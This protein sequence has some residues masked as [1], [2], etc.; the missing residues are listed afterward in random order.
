VHPAEEARAAG[1]ELNWS[2]RIPYS[3]FALAAAETVRINQPDYHE[4]FNAAIF[5][6]YFALGKDI[7]EWAVI[8][9]CADDV[10]VDPFAFDYEM[11]CG[12]ADN[13]LRY[14]EAQDQEH[15][16]NATASWLAGDQVA[17]GPR[18][19]PCSP[20]SAAPWVEK[21]SAPPVTRP[22]PRKPQCT[23]STRRR[24][25]LNTTSHTEEPPWEP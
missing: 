13:E 1:M 5:R 21:T 7:G 9:D 15:D 8:A 23:W 17:V 14:A 6:A 12:V 19:R 16:I 24:D 20:R 3:R 4:A 18:P 2:P 10:D 25:G 22:A 11:T